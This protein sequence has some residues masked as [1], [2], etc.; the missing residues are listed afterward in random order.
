MRAIVQDAYGS[1][2]VLRLAEIDPPEIAANEVLVDVAAAGMDRGTW[3]LMAGKPYLM[4]IIGF[5]FRRP[6]NRVPGLDVAGTVIAVGSEVTRFRPGDEVFGMS[7]G[8]FAEY[9]AVREDKLAH[10]PAK[11]SFEQA[12]VVP[13][14]GGTAVQALRDAGQVQA[15]Q[16]LL[17]I[18]ASGGV[19]T[20]AVQLAKAFEAEVTGV[21][22]TAKVDLVRSIGADHV[23]DYT[24]DEYLDGSEK[25]DLILDIGGNNSL[26]RLRRALTPHGT[27][28]LVGGEEGGSLTGGFGRQ[29]R[30][31]VVTRFVGQRLTMLVSKERSADL[32]ALRPFLESGQVVPV[33]DRTYPV[34]EVPD[35]MRHLEAGLVRGKLAITI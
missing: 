20:Y 32:D 4:R 5:G 15:G 26:S 14:S 2:E 3:H 34:A 35:A 1:S 17:I 16:K 24:R 10:K 11:L 21:S 9:A 30:A 28:V 7:R 25:Y 8:A 33:I 27:L 19:G 29:L 23:V 22:S 31:L 13:I 12:A 6:K 18:G